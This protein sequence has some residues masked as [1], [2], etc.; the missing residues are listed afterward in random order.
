MSLYM[1]RARYNAEAFKAMLANPINRESAAKALYHAAGMT[2]HHLWYTA[3][4]GEVIAVVEGSEL[5]GAA[6]GM[7]GMGSGAFSDGEVTQ[8]FT[9][10]QMAEALTNAGKIAAQYRTPGK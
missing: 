2:L 6:V 4:K 5:S 1:I 8:M 7:V 9:M 3:V 10:D